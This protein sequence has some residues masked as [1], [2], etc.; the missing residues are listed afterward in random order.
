MNKASSGLTAIVPLDLEHRP[1]DIIKKAEL[2]AAAAETEK[3]SIVFGL[4]NRNRSPDRV[5]KERLKSYSHVEISDATLDF[6]S[7][8]M[9]ALRN[10]AYSKVNTDFVTLLDVDIWPDFQLLKKYQ[11]QIEDGQ[12]PY[13]I[14]P[15]IYLTAW[16]SKKLLSRRETPKSLTTKFFSFSRKEFMHVA[17]PSSVTIMKKEDYRR[18]DGFNQNFM[19]HGYEDFDFMIRLA[20]LYNEV[21]PSS[22]FLQPQDSRSPLFATGFKKELGRI[23]FGPLLAKDFTY[24]LHHAKNNA[25]SFNS[26][27]KSN[28]NLFQQLH[29]SFSNEQTEED[30]TLISEF[31]KHCKVQGQSIKDYSALFENKPGHVDRYDTL[32]RRMKFL[33]SR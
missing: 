14:L 1:K 21:L 23:C 9:S 25:S 13:Y 19:G 2:L 3:V 10:L 31:L 20:S 11:Q 8:N 28:F 33:F 24:H 7:V 6:P 30:N 16:G 18:I 4:N 5:L 27:R 15:C 26:S 22:D 32:R 12:R 17:S 29:K